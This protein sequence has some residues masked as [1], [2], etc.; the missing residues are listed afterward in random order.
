M[1][2]GVCGAAHSLAAALML[3]VA[4]GA[5]SAQAPRAQ[6]PRTPQTQPQPQPPAA[7]PAAPTQ[8]PQQTTATYGDWVVR[9]EIQVG[10][11]QQK[12]CDMEQLAQ[13]QGQTGPI[14]RI[15]LPLPAKGQPP[16]LVVQLPVNVSL[17][18]GIKILADAK[19]HGLLAPFRRCVPAGCFAEIDIKD[20]ELKRFR[21]E[22]EAGK[23][24][25]KDAAERD[26]AIPVSFKGFAQ[27]FEAL[28]KQ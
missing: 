5:A 15:A 11:P 16:R 22:A 6:A 20:E 14:S 3:T 7:P 28:L 12:N 10:P 19:D 26:I 25:Y 13:V 23:M 27:A 24:Q 9:C 8:A 4:V 18:T 21:G 2:T 17:T 1:Q